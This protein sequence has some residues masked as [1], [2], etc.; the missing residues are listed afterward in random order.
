M[1]AEAWGGA[2]G[3][4]G[5]DGES[6]GE[7]GAAGG[8]VI[9]GSGVAVAMGMTLTATG[10][11]PSGGGV[12]TKVVGKATVC[13]I[14]VR[15]RVLRAVSSTSSSRVRA[16]D[17]AGATVARARVSTT[18]VSLLTDPC[19]CSMHLRRAGRRRAEM[20]VMAIPC[21][22]RF[23]PCWLCE[24]QRSERTRSSLTVLL[25]ARS[26]SARRG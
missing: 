14:S 4:A 2:L 26:A 13:G 6:G 23:S 8:V 24:V 21:W 16:A 22:R 9:T 12:Y 20:S 25:R 10:E 3:A 11:G 15:G 17:G 7:G 1:G 18:E 19:S 5:A